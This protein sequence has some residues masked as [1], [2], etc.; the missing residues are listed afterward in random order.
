MGSLDQ[1][2][3]SLVEMTNFSRAQPFA[4][5]VWIAIATKSIAWPAK[6]SPSK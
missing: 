1:V 2:K 3:D 4:P 6:S 5:I